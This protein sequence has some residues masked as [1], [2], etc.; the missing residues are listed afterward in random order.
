M[1]DKE[2]SGRHFTTSA[3]HIVEQ[4]EA[5][6][7]DRS[8]STQVI[9]HTILMLA[10]W[11]L[12]RGERKLG[13]AALERRGVETDS[14]ARD[15]DRLLKEACAEIRQRTGPPK[16]QTLPSGEDYIAVALAPLLAAAEHEAL[17]LGHNWV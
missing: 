14:L 9:P 17:G 10:L 16:L 13:L 15:V 12:L 1:H 11:S 8:M 4:L 2:L 3:I 6:A 5:R 7:A